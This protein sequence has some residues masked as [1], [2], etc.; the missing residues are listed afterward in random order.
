ML[1]IYVLVE[2]LSTERGAATT[3]AGKN[4]P[5]IFL[6]GSC[7]AYLFSNCLQSSIAQ[8]LNNTI[9]I[10]IYVHVFIYVCMSFLR[11]RA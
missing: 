6:A 3:G 1:Q 8:G 9:D 7:Q 4:F 11:I 5:Y 2:D 10:G